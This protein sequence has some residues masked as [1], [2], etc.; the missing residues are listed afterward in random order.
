MTAGANQSDIDMTGNGSSSPGRLLKKRCWYL[1]AL[2]M[3]ALLLTTVL[4]EIFDVDRRVAAHFYRPEAGWYLA[5]APVWAWLYTYGTIPGLILTLTALLVSLAGLYVQRLKPLSRPCLL[6]VLTTIIAAGLLVNAVLKQYW[7]RPRPDQ[8]IE[9][10]GKWAYRP[11]FPPGPPGKGASF[12]CGHCTMGFVFLSMAGFYRQNK[13]AAVSGLAAGVVLGVLLSA[14]RIAQ[15]AHFLSDTIWSMGIVAMTV[16]ILY[17]YFSPRSQ[18]DRKDAGRPIVR[19][20]RILITSAAIV[21]TLIMAGGFSTRRPFYETMV[22]PFEVVPDLEAVRI[23][24][25]AD[26]ERVTVHYA[27]QQMGRL[28]VDAHGFGWL[29]F[30]YHMDFNA[31]QQGRSL[32]ITLD[33]MA[34]SYFAELEHAL[35]LT[36][37]RNIGD[38]V[39]VIVNDRLLDGIHP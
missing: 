35:T 9:F 31:R 28:Q 32:Y 37:P 19:S 11:I 8:T 3:A 34:R 13:V 25:N 1:T 20:R 16:S 24:I 30:D 38:R 36:L 7:G 21:G 6:V 27:D 22:Y 12:P 10:G 2:Q 39:T 29:K 14:A 26:P 18:E 5:K 15:G 17:A 4:L 33:V 23:R